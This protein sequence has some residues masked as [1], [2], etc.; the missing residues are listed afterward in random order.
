MLI[1]NYSLESWIRWDGPHYLDIARDGYQ[2]TGEPSLYIVFYPLY[3]LLVKLLSLFISDFSLAGI[4]LSTILGLISSILLYE[5]ARLDSNHKTA[6]LS[7]WFL[8]I[9]P[10]SYFL[11]TS[12]T[13]SLFLTTSLLTFL[14]F[15][16]Q[17]FL[18][19]G[20]AGALSS[21]SRVNGL[22]LAPS[23]L[24]ETNTIRQFIDLC[25][26]P[27]GFI[28]YLGINYY[29]FNDPFYFTKPLLTNWYKKFEY[30]WTSVKNLYDS[31]PPPN[32]YY[33]ITH[34]AELTALIFLVSIIIWS[35]FKIR[36]SYVLYLFLNLM[37]FTSTSFIISTPRYLLVLFPI[38]IV[39]AT[40]KSKILIGLYSFISLSC[41]FYFFD[42]YIRGQWAF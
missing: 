6:L 21:F 20:F 16:K 11:Q 15:R 24:L 35:F 38:Y 36:R 39:L 19:S 25:L 27:L 2:T 5:L 8:N 14:L 22:L 10:T 31:T 32:D 17:V 1:P 7:V 30:P 12:Y 41:L 13:E 40:L 26:I 28:S 42:L 4:T 3:P 33:Y 23:L 9:F 37:L 29:Y 18:L 34:L